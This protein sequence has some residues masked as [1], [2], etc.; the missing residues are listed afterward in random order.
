MAK[1]MYQYPNGMKCAVSAGQVKAYEALVPPVALIVIAVGCAIIAAMFFDRADSVWS[2]TKVLAMCAGWILL[3]VLV[4]H[5]IFLAW[6]KPVLN[7]E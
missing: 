4:A 6:C 7:L 1:D 5:R 3:C 2:V